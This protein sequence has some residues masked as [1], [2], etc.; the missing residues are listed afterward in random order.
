MAKVAVHTNTI[1]C[2]LSFCVAKFIWQG[3]VIRELYALSCCRL[4]FGRKYT[5]KKLAVFR[6]RFGWTG[7]AAT[8]T[9]FTTTWLDVIFGNNAQAT[10]FCYR[11]HTNGMLKMNDAIEYAND[12]TI[13]RKINTLKI[14]VAFVGVVV[15]HA[16]P[17]MGKTFDYVLQKISSFLLAIAIISYR[18]YTMYRYTVYTFPF[19][20]FPHSFWWRHRLWWRQFMYRSLTCIS[21][22]H[23]IMN[24]IKKPTRQRTWQTLK[25]KI[26]KGEW[27]ILLA[28]H[29]YSF[30][31]RRQQYLRSLAAGC[32]SR[33]WTR[34]R[35]LYI[36]RTIKRT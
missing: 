6:S 12:Y 4:S 5:H 20:Q 10:A 9:A 22:G 31:Y 35:H 23:L 30:S 8:A 25:W 18:P 27:K 32:C 14:L 13:T 28:A 2:I 19:H 33:I 3:V 15:V 34:A 29:R 7:A 26:R 17:A 21:L 36:F 16:D 1:K 24:E 11:I